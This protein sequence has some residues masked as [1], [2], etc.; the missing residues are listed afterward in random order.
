LILLSSFPDED[1]ETFILT[2]INGKHSLGYN[3]VSSAL[4][5]H[6][7]RRKNKE[8]SSNTSADVLTVRG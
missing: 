4:A 3:E 1:Y 7:L 6:E 2:I 8:S 5:N